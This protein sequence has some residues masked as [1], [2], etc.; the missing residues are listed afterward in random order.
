MNRVKKIITKLLPGVAGFFVVALSMSLT[1]FADG[2]LTV[3]VQS[4][5]VR[6]SASTSGTVVGGVNKN[7]TYD[8]IASETDSNSYTWYKIKVSDTVTGY[9]RADLVTTEGTA[10]TAPAETSSTET[11]PAAEATTVTEVVPV[12][13]SVTGDVRVR[14]GASTNHDVVTTAKANTA[15]MVTGFATASDG[16]VWYQVSYTASNG[17]VNGFIRNDYVKLD[18]DLTEKV[19]EPIPEVTPEPVVVEPEPEEVVYKDYEVVYSEED[20]TWY[21]NNYIEGTKSSVP[22]LLEAKNNLEKKEKEFKAQLKKKKVTIGILVAIIIALLGLGVYAYISVR[23]WYY[24]SE[25]ETEEPA[26]SNSYG[27]DSTDR[28]L[29]TTQSSGVRVQT[30]GAEPKTVTPEVNAAKGN[31]ETPKKNILAGETL[32]DGTVRMPDGSIRKKV[33]AVRLS[34]GSIKYPDGTIKKPDGTIIKPGESTEAHAGV[35]TGASSQEVRQVKYSHTSESTNDDDMEYGFLSFDK[36][37]DK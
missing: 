24:G 32:P 21:L 13:G 26:H 12:A 31:V 28:P 10:E 11:A 1:A 30:V 2:K 29:R 5:Y 17:D 16:N 19:E 36:D 33:Y 3:N 9:I 37:S 25:D 15:V 34:D 14:A 23:R 6:S 35:H 22:E 8:I 4:A 27:R 20:D 7:E 18:G